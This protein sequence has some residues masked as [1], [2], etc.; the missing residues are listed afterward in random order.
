MIKHE[1]TIRNVRL[2]TR[3]ERQNWTQE[4]L[5]EMIGT[6]AVSISRW[7]NGLTPSSHFRTQLCEQFHCTPQE[8]GWFEDELGDTEEGPVLVP[9]G[10]GESHIAAP[11]EHY[12]NVARAQ[13]ESHMQPILSFMRRGQALHLPASLPDEEYYVLPGREKDIQ[14]MLAVLS[15]QHGALVIS[16]ESLGGQGKTAIAVE[17]S[18]RAVAQG[19]FDAVVGASAKQ[20]AL[21]D[22]EIV[23][24]RD[25][26]L[27]FGA[28]LDTIE[29]QLDHWE[30][31]TLPVA[32]KRSKVEQLLHQRR[33]LV[34]VDNLETAND[35]HTLISSLKGLL[36][37]SRAIVT[38]RKRISYDFVHTHSLHPLT[39]DDALFFLRQDIQR[40]GASYL[41]DIPEEKLVEMYEVTGGTPLA[42]KLAVALTRILDLAV[43]LRQLER[44]GSNLYPFIFSQSWRHLSPVAQRVLIYLGTTAVAS[45]SWKELAQAQVATTECQLM[46]AVKQLIAYSL[47]DVSTVAN[48]KHYSIH[49]LTRNF[50]A[51]NVSTIWSCMGVS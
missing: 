20:E 16:V 30:F 48:Q 32:E 46:D 6:T 31:Y 44:A 38:S 33:C 2:R 9:A 29:R 25:A 15:E 11:M 28:L 50:V 19:M 42:L 13:Q 12:R 39:L 36:G 43:V 27:D 4:Q 35:P 47:L 37:R 18:R 3:R 45:V 22:G 26:A 10:Q 7:E 5:A 34:F 1:P 17:L 49:Q 8:L 41:L 23:P 14:E 40:H 51:A 24:I 21:M